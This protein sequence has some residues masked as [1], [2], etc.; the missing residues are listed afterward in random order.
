MHFATLKWL[1][2]F[3]LRHKES[4][5]RPEARFFGVGIGRNLQIPAVIAGI[6]SVIRLTP[7]CGNGAYRI[8]NEIWSLSPFGETE[9]CLEQLERIH[10]CTNPLRRQANQ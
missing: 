4:T 2:P 6:E 1:H 9:G 5:A 7:V 8:L 10:E 3:R